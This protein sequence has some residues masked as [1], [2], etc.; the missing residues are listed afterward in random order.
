LL[1]QIGSDKLDVEGLS[2]HQGDHSKLLS[3]LDGM[4]EFAATLQSKTALVETEL[5]GMATTSSSADMKQAKHS[6]KQKIEG[7]A[8]QIDELKS[9]VSAIENAPLLGEAAKLEAGCKDV[10]SKVGR[11][12]ALF[13]IDGLANP[14]A[15]VPSGGNMAPMKVR[16]TTYSGYADNVLRDLAK[17]ER[18]VLGNSYNSP[19]RS[20]RSSASIKD[21][22]AMLAEKL[23]DIQQRVTTVANAPISNDMLRTEAAASSLSSRALALAKRVGLDGKISQ[24]GEVSPQQG[25]TLKVRAAALEAVLD[26]VQTSTAVLEDELA[27]NAGQLPAQMQQDGTLKS[28]VQLLQ[29]RSENLNSRLSTMEQQ[30]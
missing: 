2:K 7:L 9:R 18:E 3:R 5:F 21:S 25:S 29:Q 30:V 13:G 10:G 16:L 20:Q 6:F 14:A 11:M 28:R 22:A 23:N 24:Q 27:G 4:Q 12:F 26:K 15:T 1:K 8:G 19:D 17:L